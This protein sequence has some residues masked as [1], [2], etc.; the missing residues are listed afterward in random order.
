M[1][2]SE[3]MRSCEGEVFEYVGTAW[4]STPCRMTGR[5]VADFLK[6]IPEYDCSEYLITSDQ[7]VKTGKNPEIILRKV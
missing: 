5:E 2:L 4:G 7:V 6:E 3:Y 1:L